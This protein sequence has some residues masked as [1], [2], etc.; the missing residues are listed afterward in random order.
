[1]AQVFWWEVIFTAATF[2]VLTAYHVYWIFQL[3]HEPLKTYLGIT[4]HLRRMWVQ[5]IMQERRDILAVQTLRN[6]IMASS[7]LASTAILIGLGL[8]SLLFKPEHFIETAPLKPTEALSQQLFGR[9]VYCG[10]A[11][12]RSQQKHCERQARQLALGVV[13]QAAARSRNGS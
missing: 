11:L 5:S 7:F 1:M 9:R 4:K 3:K 10:K 2:M 13:H 12:A 8:L 6:W